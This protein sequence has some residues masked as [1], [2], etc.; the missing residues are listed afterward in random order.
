MREK[1]QHCFGF[2]GNCAELLL[3]CYMLCNC[4]F[5]FHFTAFFVNCKFLRSNSICRS[6]C[7][8]LPH[9]C[10][11][12]PFPPIF[13]IGLR[14]DYYKTYLERGTFECQMTFLKS[15]VTSHLL[16]WSKWPLLALLP[17]LLLR[18]KVQM[19]NLLER[20]L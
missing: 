10:S 3:L 19:E 18:S 12:A 13:S 8:S 6:R 4:L 20:L 1:L 16:L 9:Q 5:D 14:L 2:L 17:E 7:L 15:H 11:H